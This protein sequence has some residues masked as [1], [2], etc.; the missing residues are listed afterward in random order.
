M[1]YE[2]EKFAEASV[3][4]LKRATDFIHHI[5]PALKGSIV[6][7]IEKSKPFD[8]NVVFHLMNIKETEKQVDNRAIL[9]IS[10]EYIL[11]HA[12]WKE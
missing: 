7:A 4:D 8:M 3:L 9:M 6:Y 12:Y 5:K 1:T 2:F 11:E 10:S